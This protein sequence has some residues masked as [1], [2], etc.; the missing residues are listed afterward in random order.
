MGNVRRIFLDCYA[1]Y[2]TATG[3]TVVMI[4]DT[5]EAIR[6]NLLPTLVTQ[7]MKSLP[8]TLFILSGRPMRI[9]GGRESGTRSSRAGRPAPADAGHQGA[10][11]EFSGRRPSG[12]WGTAG[13]RRAW[14]P[15]R[16]R[17]SSC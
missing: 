6:G 4:L 5:V 8:A 13:S 15:T 14:T 7:W 17:R 10:L 16:E 3:K 12:T 1:D 9:A 11:G 2:V